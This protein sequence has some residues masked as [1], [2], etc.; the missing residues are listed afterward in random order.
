MKC[1]GIEIITGLYAR[2]R[3]EVHVGEGDLAS[4]LASVHRLDTP[5]SRHVPC[6]RWYPG[7][8]SPGLAA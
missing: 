2:V 1:T 7:T 3:V 4:N 8:F 6:P 5:S